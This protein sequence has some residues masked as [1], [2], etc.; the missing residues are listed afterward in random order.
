MTIHYAAATNI[1]VGEHSEWHLFGMTFNADTIISTVAASVLLIGV[2]LYVRA[3]ATSGVPG[4]IQL[5]FEAVTKFLGDQVETAVGLRVAPYLIPVS[6]TLFFFL[7]IAN[8]FS[9][10]PL[11]VN[12]KD[13]LPPPAGDVNLVFALALLVFVWKHASGARR[14]HGL[15]RQFMHTV[16]GH[17]KWLFPMWIIEEISGVMSHAL[18][19]F[20]NILAGG[21][22][23]EVIAA[24]IPPEI[25]WALNGG[26]KLFDLFIGAVQAFIF[27]FLTIIYFGQAME[28]REEH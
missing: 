11:S 14:H 28:L 12:G 15:G 23:I 19:L 27:S 26:W 24:L 16:K 9:A 4:G 22:M 2:G 17:Q 13:L 6:V 25:G 3:K 20:G 5:F 8:W 7:L 18:R 1:T 10:L 21:I